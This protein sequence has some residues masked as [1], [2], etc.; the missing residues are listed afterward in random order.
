MSHPNFLSYPGKPAVST[1]HPADT[2]KCRVEGY[3][4]SLYPNDRTTQDYP[5]PVAHEEPF[6]EKVAFLKVLAEKEAKAREV[7]YRGWSTCRVCNQYNGSTEFEYNGWRWPQGYRHYV[8]D[9]NV[10]PSKDFMKFIL[11]VKT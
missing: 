10:A 1:A 3:W 5:V 2:D 8:E 7:H 9:H 4:R 6:P 11:S